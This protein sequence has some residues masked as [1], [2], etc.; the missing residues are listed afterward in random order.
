MADDKLQR[1][2]DFQQL[3]E[4]KKKS[5]AFDVVIQQGDH[6]KNFK[7]MHPFWP[8]LKD[9]LNAMRDAYRADT[10]KAARDN[11]AEIANYLGREEG[12]MDVLNLIDQFSAK[13]EQAQIEKNLADEQINELQ[14]ILTNP[15]RDVT[16]VGGAM[17]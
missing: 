13:A 5:E 11:R 15:Q 4:L 1:D 14:N 3:T 16:D 8:I 9:T 10:F 12:I 7:D 17:G 2:E 6:A